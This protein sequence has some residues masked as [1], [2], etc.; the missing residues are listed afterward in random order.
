MPCGAS[1]REGRDHRDERGVE[2][3]NA[4]ELARVVGA[5]HLAGDLSGLLGGRCVAAT[6]RLAHGRDGVLALVEV[7][8]GLVANGDQLN[9]DTLRLELGNTVLGLLD[10]LGVVAAA[11]AAVARD[12]EETHG[13]GIAAL[14]E[15]DVE[16]LGAKAR[17][18]T[19][20]DAL[21]GLGERA[22]AQA[23][24]LGA[25]HLGGSDELHRGGDL[26]G[27][28][29]RRDAVTQLTNVGTHHNAAAGRR[30]GRDSP[31]AAASTEGR[32]EGRH[33]SEEGKEQRQHGA[34][35]VRSSAVE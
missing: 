30:G 2:E 4:V 13:L 32:L 23:S 14:K 28:L 35:E 20:E 10:N 3:L 7:L 18:Q 9:T 17:E 16:R 22:L 15:R 11:K 25:A 27:V 6:H 24:L 21:E 26:A 33:A 8:A 19:A 34:L 12:D 29:D 31:V 5:E 1:G